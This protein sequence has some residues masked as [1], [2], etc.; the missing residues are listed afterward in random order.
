MAFHERWFSAPKQ[1]RLQL[2]LD[3]VATSEGAVIEVGCWEGRSTITIANHFAPDVVHCIDHWLGDLTN[4]SSGVQAIAATRDVFADFKE[5]MDFATAGNYLVHRM[6]WRD[7]DWDEIGPIRFL[8]IDGEH[9][10]S[11]VYDN[12]KATEHLWLPG[13]IIAGDDCTVPGVGRAVRAYFN[14][15][16]DEELT[17]TGPGA[18]IWAVP[19]NHR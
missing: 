7:L 14:E 12:L 8:F 4:P 13:S 19:I 1:R 16:S 6:G 5:N 3:A 15:V 9:T 2:A 17:C 11:E 18:A 10:Y